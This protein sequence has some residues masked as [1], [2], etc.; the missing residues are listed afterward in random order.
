MT[1]QTRIYI[2]VVGVKMATPEMTPDRWPGA[3]D[4]ESLVR[5]CR[6][7]D[8]RVKSGDSAGVPTASSPAVSAF[9]DAALVSSILESDFGRIIRRAGTPGLGLAPMVSDWRHMADGNTSSLLLFFLFSI[10]CFC[11]GW[12]LAQFQENSIFR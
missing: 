12:H 11:F 9:E 5:D 7:P 3:H 4:E 10:F 1:Y 2:S 8:R 6:P